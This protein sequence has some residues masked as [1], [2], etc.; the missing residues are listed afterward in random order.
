MDQDTSDH[1]T[2]LESKEEHYAAKR[3]TLV[4]IGHELSIRKKKG[5]MGETAK[6]GFASPVLLPARL[7]CI[8]FL[9]Q[10]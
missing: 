8:P 7:F 4:G 1:T 5:H 10:G 6:S 3:I 9:S 2:F